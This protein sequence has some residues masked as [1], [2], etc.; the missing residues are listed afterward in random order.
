MQV[1]GMFFLNIYIL[2]KMNPTSLKTNTYLNLNFIFENKY[3][4]KDLGV[5]HSQ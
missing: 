3:V 2:N 1:A 4:Q 5:F